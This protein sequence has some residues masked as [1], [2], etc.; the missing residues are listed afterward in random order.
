MNV[1]SSR[2]SGS[3]GT[4]MSASLPGAGRR[5]SR[6]YLD[7][8]PDDIDE[9]LH[10]HGKY[11]GHGR[12]VGESNAALLPLLSRVHKSKQD[13]VECDVGLLHRLW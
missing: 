8:S 11:D 10:D 12:R 9:V 1:T 3:L 5:R 13:L 6:M 4:H 7:F 2:I